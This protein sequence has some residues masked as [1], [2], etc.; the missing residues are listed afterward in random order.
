MITNTDP[1]A[2]SNVRSRMITKLPYAIVSPSTRMWALLDAEDM[3]H[4]REDAVRDDDIDDRSHR[5]PRRGVTDR[6]RAPAGAHALHAARERHQ[7]AEYDALADA[8]RE[9]RDGDRALRLLPVLRRAEVEHRGPDHHAAQDS[10]EVGVDR[11]ERHDEPDEK[12]DER[13]DRQ[14][15]CARLLDL[16]HEI[17][18]AIARVPAEEARERARRLAQEGEELPGLFGRLDGGGSY[19]D[20]KRR[21]RSPTAR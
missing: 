4:D 14:C 8:G 13:D 2:T 20:E 10:D 7:H 17:H 6:G 9:I 15:S 18:P 12:A 16:E 3:E 11:E 19:P 1:R 21:A 5:R